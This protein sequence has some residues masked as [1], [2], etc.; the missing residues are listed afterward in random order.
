MKELEEFTLEIEELEQIR[1][2]L[3]QMVNSKEI[4]NPTGAG[5]MNIISQIK[6]LEARIKK[7][8]EFFEWLKKKIS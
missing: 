8:A 1:S 6:T 2:I 3:L 7:N 4:A 5:L